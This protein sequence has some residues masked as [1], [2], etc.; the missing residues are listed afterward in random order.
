MRGLEE[1]CKHLITPL[2]TKSPTYLPR[3][4]A[5]ITKRMGDKG[6][7]CLRPQEGLKKWEE[8]PLTKIAIEEVEIN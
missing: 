7:P 5:I 4:S 3:Q 8:P 1:G 2:W 6:S